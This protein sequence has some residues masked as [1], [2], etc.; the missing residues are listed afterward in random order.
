MPYDLTLS[1]KNAGKREVVYTV[2][3]ARQ[4]TGLTQAEVAAIAEAGS[5]R[6]AQREF[7]KVAAEK[8]AGGDHD[9]VITEE[10]PLPEPPTSRYSNI[11]SQFRP[12]A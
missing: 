8:E 1:V 11:P 7:Q 10:P 12:G 3:P 9:P 2:V 4:N 6:D 5:L